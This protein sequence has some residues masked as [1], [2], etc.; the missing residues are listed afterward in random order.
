MSSGA[1]FLI[2]SLTLVVTFGQHWCILH[3][4]GRLNASYNP[5]VIQFHSALLLENIY[6]IRQGVFGIHPLIYFLLNLKH[7]STLSKEN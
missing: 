2:C 1:T 3:R 4:K 7:V 5:A 6:E